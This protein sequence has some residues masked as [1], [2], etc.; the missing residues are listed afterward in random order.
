MRPLPPFRRW[1]FE[2][3]LQRLKSGFAPVSVLRGPRQVVKI[4]LQEHLIEHPLRQEGV[5]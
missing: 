3:T 5:D 4:N 1:L 2:H